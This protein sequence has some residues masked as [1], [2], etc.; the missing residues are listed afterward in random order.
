M[1]LYALNTSKCPNY[2]SPDVPIASRGSLDATMLF[3]SGSAPD[4]LQ[5][6]GQGRARARR[7]LEQRCGGA[8]ISAAWCFAPQHRA[9]EELTWDAIHIA[10]LRHHMQALLVSTACDCKAKSNCPCSL[11]KVLQVSLRQ[12][13]C[14]CHRFG[15]ALPLPGDQ[16]SA[17]FD[18]P[19]QMPG[20]KS[21]DVQLLLL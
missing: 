16:R 15:L 2:Y 9:L 1:Y 6:C 8:K 18:S 12:K 7:N 4:Q 14:M 21:F 3:E 19:A 5:S 11:V 13:C 17:G 10:T 20:T